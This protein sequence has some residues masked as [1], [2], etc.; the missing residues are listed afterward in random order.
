M[1]HASGHRDCGQKHGT[2]PEAPVVLAGTTTTGEW[3]ATSS[4]CGLGRRGG[5]RREGVVKRLGDSGGGG[6][7]A[8]CESLMDLFEDGG[9]IEEVGVGNRK[10]SLETESRTLGVV[11]AGALTCHA[12]SI[13]GDRVGHP[14]WLVCDRF[15]ATKKAGGFPRG[16]MAQRAV[17]PVATVPKSQEVTQAFLS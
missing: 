17:S 1:R 14:G 2:R 3:R 6:I 15:L 9:L 13:C 11:A 7:L 10:F 5:R 16:A 4:F 12:C 8:M